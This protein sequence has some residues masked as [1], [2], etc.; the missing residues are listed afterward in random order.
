M[1]HKLFQTPI[2]QETLPTRVFRQLNKDILHDIEIIRKMDKAGIE[3]SKENY[4]N[5][6]T[7]YSSISDIHLRYAP[8]M[9]LKAHLDKV[10]KKFTKSLEVDLCGRKL[11]MTTCWIN[12]MAQGGHHS[13][14]LHP[15]CFL[16]GTYYVQTPPG[17]GEI[18]FEDPRMGLFMGAPPLKENLKMRDSYFHKI[19]PSA[20]DILM[21][22]SWLKHE[23][24]A[25]KS[26][27][28]RVSISFNYEWV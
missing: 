4:I 25:N 9:E 2:V 28:Q 21:W 15:L 16:S 12:V 22:E 24:T 19:Q 8:F 5:G 11:E 20:G 6:Y 1:I 7:S 10:A 27:S 13:L 3:W 17:A 23:V 18:K 26:K 14:H